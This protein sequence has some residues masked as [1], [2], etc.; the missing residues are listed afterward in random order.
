MIYGSTCNNS[1]QLSWER[2]EYLQWINATCSATRN[3]NNL[4]ANWTSLLSVQ[5]NELLPWHWE[6]RSENT[7]ASSSTEKCSSTAAKLGAF[8]AVNAAMAVIT[9]ILGR[10]DV[11]KGLTFGICGRRGSKFWM[12]SG[13]LTAMFHISS[14]I[15]AALLIKHTPGFSNVNVLA[16][17]LLWCTR[18][19]LAWF[20]VV[21]LPWGAKDHIYFSVA[22]STL[23]AEIIMQLIGSYYMGTATQYARVQKFYHFGRLNNV[24]HGKDAITMYA[25][26]LLWLTVVTFAVVACSMSV[27]NVNQYV[28]S[29]VGMLLGREK[30]DARKFSLR[31]QE[32]I[33]RLSRQRE[34]ARKLQE[35]HPRILQLVAI[36]YES[37]YPTLLKNWLAMVQT[38]QV[39]V[40][41][42][43]VDI[44]AFRRLEKDYEK[45]KRQE[46][47]KTRR[48]WRKYVN[49]NLASDLETATWKFESAK[50]RITDIPSDAL[51]VIEDGVWI[52]SASAK[53]KERLD[54][55]LIKVDV[56]RSGNILSKSD[57]KLLVKI[58][59]DLR[60]LL[61]SWHTINKTILESFE[62]AWRKQ[63]EAREAEEA[64]R[65]RD[66]SERLKS[67]A[68]TTVF[69]MFGCWV[70]QWVWWYGYIQVSAGS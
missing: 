69:G 27:F 24:V 23:L 66:P 29:L 51:R 40:Y 16:L 36:P 1:C 8:L 64:E 31:C 48:Q 4:P 55:S 58:A 38:W 46:R 59:H 52:A 19:R 57:K 54:E 65:N 12:L 33:K 53:A 61:G 56:Y 2:A 14:N 26:S 50:A 32:E 67:I 35:T 30:K 68:N 10:R 41:Y 11:M 15:A 28:S 43:E 22:S 60:D 34:R 42:L 21:L 9:P 13:P 18:P 62:A 17:I 20:V 25:G 47:A 45:K 3:S 5:E 49:P 63:Q 37:E 6:V 44:P 70:A 7:T 39:L